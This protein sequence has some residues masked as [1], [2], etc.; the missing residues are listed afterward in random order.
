MKHTKRKWIAVLLM[1]ALLTSLTAAPVAASPWGD[2]EEDDYRPVY[3]YSAVVNGKMLKPFTLTGPYDGK[4]INLYPVDKYHSAYLWNYQSNRFEYVQPRDEA[5]AISGNFVQLYDM[6]N[7]GIDNINGVLIVSWKDSEAYWDSGRKWNDDFDDEGA[8]SGD[9]PWR[10]PYGQRLLDGYGIDGAAEDFS[11]I[12]DYAD[13]QGSSYWP[14]HDYYGAA[15]GGGL[16]ML[17]GFRTTQQATGWTCGPTSALMVMDWFGL[18]GD[19][20]EQDLSALRNA[21]RQTGATN[22]QQMINIF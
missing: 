18:R 8:F 11:N 4:T 12:L 6:S 17:T 21:T 1:L 19:L 2:E 16:A 5:K 7:D 10:L 15:S 20:N 22:L 9:Q 14:L 3:P 13:L